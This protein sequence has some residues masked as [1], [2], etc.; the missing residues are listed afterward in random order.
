MDE[1]ER[2]ARRIAVAA[3]AKL[4]I[5]YGKEMEDGQI[6]IYINA[7]YDLSNSLDRAVDRIISTERYFPAVATIR[8]AAL[9]DDTRL[10]PEEA[11]GFITHMIQA[12]GR[13]ASTRGLNQE[14]KAAVNAC[15]GYQ[16]L[17][18][19]E[20]RTGDRI[21]FTRAYTAYLERVDRRRAEVWRIPQT[22][23][24]GMEQIGRGT[25]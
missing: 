9:R 12:M 24:E 21:T 23:R 18:A 7:L 4:S 22:L 11:W 13:T 5:A 1:N 16:A 3:I 10:S 19:S 6:D 17:C 14:T 25:I 20:N 15:G 2:Q 8:A